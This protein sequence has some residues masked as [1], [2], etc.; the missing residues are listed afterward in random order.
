[1]DNNMK[2]FSIE[3]KIDKLFAYNFSPPDW[4]ITKQTKELY[5]QLSEPIVRAAVSWQDDAGRI[6]D[7]F[8]HTEVPMATARFVGALGGLISANRCIDLVDICAKSM[9]IACKNLFEASH[10]YVQGAPFYTKELMRG[11]LALK[12]K[13]DVSRVKTW[14]KLL[15]DYN[16]EK[17][18]GFYVP[19]YYKLQPKWRTPDRL[20]NSITF[21]LA[22]EGLKKKY[23]IADHSEWIE[24]YIE[25]QIENFT[26][27]GM[28]RD[29][30]DPMTYDWV[31]RMNLSLLFYAGYDGR[32]APFF[33][34][35]LRRGALTMLLYLSSTGEAPFG[36]R[37]NQYQHNEATIAVI[38]E[39]EANRYKHIGNMKAAGVF[40]RAARLAALSTKQWIHSYP[41]RNIKNQFMPE[42]KHGYQK[43]Y[44]Y[45]SVY[46]LL[47]ASQFGFAYMLADDTIEEKSSPYEIGGYILSLPGAFHKVF[48][49][50][51]KYHI[52]IDTK[53]DFHYDATGLG[54]IHHTGFPTELGLSCSI[55]S[56]PNY[57]VSSVCSPRN[58]SIGPGWVDSY[59]NM[60]WLADF[61]EDIEDTKVTVIKENEVEI[62]FYIIYTLH[63]HGIKTIKENYHLNKDGLIITDIFDG[64]P[65]NIL[66]Q[67]PLLKTNGKYCSEII[68]GKNS[69]TV[70]YQN[71]C[72]KVENI[73]SENISELF[74]ESFVSP[75]RNGIYNVGCFKTQG[76]R[77]SYKIS[78]MKK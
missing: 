50:C 77:I 32:H 2:L 5:M 64:S 39:Y 68:T 73:S 58:I 69:F 53:A 18:Y 49:T 55:V 78:F 33:D 6:I 8:E 19:Y 34:E 38:C 62:E 35:I 40:K 24:K 66:V 7:P 26:E 42:T 14:K 56:K 13:I 61:S 44:G 4:E 52:E 63:S 9:D 1:M 75:N 72:Y 21:G 29:P 15:G 59:D 65:K 31:S 23:G 27:L 67:I 46:S 48:A 25:Y 12:D 54:R 70:L 43:N 3:K 11:Y 45:H 30:N 10:K 16:P 28:Y 17:N 36:G 51:Q 20:S 74:L 60:H 22:G 76:D 47:A 37:S 71:Y 57:F 41:F